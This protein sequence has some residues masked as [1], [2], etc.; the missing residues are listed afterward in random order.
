MKINHS[1]IFHNEINC[2]ENF[3]DYGIS[4][5]VVAGKFDVDF[6]FLIL[7]SFYADHQINFSQYLLML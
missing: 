7:P 5:Y 1:K 3:P 2:N 6:I 4:Q